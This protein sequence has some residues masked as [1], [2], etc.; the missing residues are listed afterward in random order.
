MYANSLDFLYPTY[1]NYINTDIQFD[2]L[3]MFRNCNAIY[4]APKGLLLYVCAVKYWCW[5]SFGKE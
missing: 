5:T 4:K 1:S 3:A 2:A